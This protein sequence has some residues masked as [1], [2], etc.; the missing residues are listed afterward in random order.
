MIRVSEIINAFV[1]FVILPLFYLNGDANFRTRV[2]RQGLPSALKMALFKRNHILPK[3]WQ[4]LP[5]PFCK[6]SKKNI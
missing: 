3:K 5:S 2:I 4:F 6:K 1:M